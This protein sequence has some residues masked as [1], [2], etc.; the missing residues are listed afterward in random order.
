MPGRNGLERTTERYG[1][2][3]TRMPR[4]A[5]HQAPGRKHDASPGAMP[6]DGFLGVAG[7]TGIETAVRSEQGTDTVS[8]ESDECLQDDAH[9]LITVRQCFSRLRT[10][11]ALSAVRAPDLALT[12]MSTGGSSC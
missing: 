9:C 2:V 7:T 3:S 1:I 12:T 5:A 4:V 6:F 10:I 8:V 11:A